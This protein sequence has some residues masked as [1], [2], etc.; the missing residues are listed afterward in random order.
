MLVRLSWGEVQLGSA[1][2]HACLVGLGYGAAGY[3]CWHVKTIATEYPEYLKLAVL[4]RGLLAFRVPVHG[5]MHC[6]N[7]FRI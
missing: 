5:T 6:I 1:V 4:E 7:G 3:R 2:W